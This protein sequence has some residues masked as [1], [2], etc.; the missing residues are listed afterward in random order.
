MKR[1]SMF[2]N[3]R[4]IF[5]VPK[6]NSRFDVILVKTPKAFFTNIENPQIHREPHTHTHTHKL[7]KAIL[8]IK[9]K[10]EGIITLSYFK[11]Y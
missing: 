4:N 3:W 11:I 9:K 8:S 7:D 5:G 1:H 10:A 6:A 2:V